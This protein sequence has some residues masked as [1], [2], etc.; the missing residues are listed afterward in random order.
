[1]NILYWYKY[2]YFLYIS[3][4]L[5]ICTKLVVL[6]DSPNT[7][8]TIPKSSPAVYGCYKPSLNVS[9]LLGFPHSSVPSSTNIAIENCHIYSGFAHGKWWIFPYK[10]PFSHGFPMVFPWFS[11]GFPMF[12]WFTRGEYIQCAPK[13]ARRCVRYVRGW[14]P[15]RSWRSARGRVSFLSGILAMKNGGFTIYVSQYVIYV[16]FVIYIYIY[17]Q[18]W[19]H[20]RFTIKNG[21]STLANGRFRYVSLTWCALHKSQKWFFRCQKLWFNIPNFLL[22]K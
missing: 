3:V 4:N 21:R 13:F 16:I 20:Y 19:F 22:Q 15:L 17:S 9:S 10:S 1:M 12:L 8:G 18:K 11:H 7:I 2:G 5:P 6:W 14:R